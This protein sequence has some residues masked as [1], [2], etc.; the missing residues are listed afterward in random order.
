MTVLTVLTPMTSFNVSWIALQI[1]CVVW[2]LNLTWPSVNPCPSREFVTQLNQIFCTQST[3]LLTPQTLSLN[4]S[5]YIVT[6]VCIALK[7]LGFINPVVSEF[8]LARSLKTIINIVLWYELLWSLVLSYEIQR[9]RR[10]F[11]KWYI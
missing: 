4:L 10:I 9:I 8:K 11:K 5:F 6:S 2:D 1:G 7:K 3:V